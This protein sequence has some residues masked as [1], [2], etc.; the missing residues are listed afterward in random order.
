MQ[1]QPDWIEEIPFDVAEWGDRVVAP[2]YAND[3]ERL[4]AAQAKPTP[5]FEALLARQRELE[6]ERLA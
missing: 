2:L 6:R 1:P 5:E 3:S 4:A